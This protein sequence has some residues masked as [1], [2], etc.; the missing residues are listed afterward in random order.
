MLRFCTLAVAGAAALGLSG[1]LLS[2][3]SPASA[4]GDPGIGMQVLDMLCTSKAGSPVNTPFT[5][6]RCQDARAG[7]GFEVEQL[8]CEGLLE[9]T[10]RS[11]ASSSRPNRVNWFCFP[12]Q[13]TP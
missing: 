5:I 1:A 6:S 2:P 12:G 10:F 13:I 4:A 3:A 9:G 8:I 7:Q 11:V